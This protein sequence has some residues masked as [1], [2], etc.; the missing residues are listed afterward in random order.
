MYYILGGLLLLAMLFILVSLFRVFTFSFVVV[1]YIIGLGAAVIA[2]ILGF[3]FAWPA[4]ALIIILAIISA[5]MKPRRE[6]H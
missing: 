4:I 5:V 2:L 1:A 6:R 3:A